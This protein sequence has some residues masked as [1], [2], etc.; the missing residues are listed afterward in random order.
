MATSTRHCSGAGAGGCCLPDRTLN[1]LR[2]AC[3]EGASPSRAEGLAGRPAVLNGGASAHNRDEGAQGDNTARE[4]PL[5]AVYNIARELPL[6]AVSAA[7]ELLLSNA[8]EATTM[9]D[10]VPRPSTQDRTR[11][12]QEKMRKKLVTDATKIMAKLQSPRIAPRE[13]APDILERFKAGQRTCLE[14]GHLATSG[15]SSLDAAQFMDSVMQA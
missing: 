9:S 14:Q 10:A 1:R 5:V 3:G 8:V 7:E 13:P 11:R 6:V 4:P 12:Q 2:M 15:I